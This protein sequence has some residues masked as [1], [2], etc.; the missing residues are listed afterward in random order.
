MLQ[1]LF[2]SKLANFADYLVYFAN[3]IALRQHFQFVIFSKNNVYQQIAITSC[4]VDVDDE[5]RMASPGGMQCTNIDFEKITMWYVI[6]HQLERKNSSDYSAM[7]YIISLLV[8]IAKSYCTLKFQNST[9]K[10]L[11]KMDIKVR[12]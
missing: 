12:V 4:M 7:H 2:V 5:R 6:H 10:A 9:F 3:K 11:C 8:S 1:L